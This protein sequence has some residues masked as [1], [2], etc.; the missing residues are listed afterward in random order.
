MAQLEHPF[1]PQSEY[2]TQITSQ[3]LEVTPMP[4][5]AT[6]PP[7]EPDQSSPIPDRTENG[8]DPLTS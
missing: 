8:L 7:T 2:T 4:R 6:S 3:E 5:E 1:H